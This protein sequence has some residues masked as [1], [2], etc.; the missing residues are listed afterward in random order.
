MI[1][2]VTAYKFIKRDAWDRFRRT[3]SDYL[4]DF[5]KLVEHID[6]PLVVYVEGDVFAEIAKMQLRSNIILIN[7]STISTFL[8]THLESERLI[9][10]S[11][12][13]KCK[14]PKVRKQ[15]P[16]HCRPEY[17]LINHSKIQY[18]SHTKRLFPGYEY[19]SWLD[20][21]FVRNDLAVIPRNLNFAKLQPKIIFNTI[22][23]IPLIPIDANKMLSVH[24]IY[25]AGSA[26]IIHTSLIECFEGLY[27]SKLNE[28]KL[29]NIADD[30]Q[31]LTYQLYC[32]NKDLFLLIPTKNW[33]SLFKEWL[34]N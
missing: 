5:K 12:D 10:E 21:G 4:Y 29:A 26:F 9:M 24:E 34:N 22:D 16:E 6:Y 33:R 15:F 7:S 2:F 3:N 23:T 8:E 11:D 18:I 13:Y 19:Y 32:E 17:T 1:L 31:N 14:I 20:F 30:D 25:I 28:W 27:T